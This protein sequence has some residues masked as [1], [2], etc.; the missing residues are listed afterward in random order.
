MIK[1]RLNCVWFQNWNTLKLRY[2]KIFNTFDTNRN[3]FPNSLFEY[4][5]KV[6][7]FYVDNIKTLKII[8]NI[9]LIIIPTLIKLKLLSLLLT[10]VSIA[11]NV[12]NLRNNSQPEFIAA[13]G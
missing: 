5:L 7:D 6:D 13:T 9:Y 12:M 4:I 3:C 11:A 2:V 1:T 8:E 10:L